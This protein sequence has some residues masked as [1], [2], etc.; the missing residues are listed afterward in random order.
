VNSITLIGR[1]A[2]EPDADTMPNGIPRVFL[3][4]AVQRPPSRD[5]ESR[6]CS[7]FDVHAYGSLA[8]A[9]SE[10][11][12]RGREIAV[13]GRL[14]QRSWRETDGTWRERIHIVA[15]RISFLREPAPTQPTP[16]M[17]AAP[18]AA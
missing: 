16:T 8:A 4:L 3:R 14:E 11:L 5:G 10:H 18:A 15:D 7:F 9:C 12:V 17:A 1:L 13:L 2:S 6:G